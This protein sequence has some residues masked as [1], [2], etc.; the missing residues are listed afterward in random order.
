MLNIIGDR[1]LRELHGT[2]A[3]G[4]PREARVSLP[5]PDRPGH[6]TPSSMSETNDPWRVIRWNR[7]AWLFPSLDVPELIERVG[8]PLVLLGWLPV[9]WPA[10]CPRCG[11]AFLIWS[12]Q[13]WGYLFRMYLKTMFAPFR[14]LDL[15]FN[16]PCPHC[17]LPLGASL[18]PDDAD[19][20]RTNTSP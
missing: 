16:G 17:G 6:L 8:L 20:A 13:N 10:P 12:I 18:G 11:Q 4:T 9:F 7:R 5:V 3:R 14:Y 2:R 1:R 15:V 19:A